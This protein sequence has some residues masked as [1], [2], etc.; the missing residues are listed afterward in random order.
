MTKVLQY[1][2]SGALASVVSDVLMEKLGFSAHLFAS[3]FGAREFVLKFALFLLVFVVF[4]ALLT[5]LSK[6]GSVH[7]R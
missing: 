3:G 7:S 4:V 1:G 6:K 2:V 5:L